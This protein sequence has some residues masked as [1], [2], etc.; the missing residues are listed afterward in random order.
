MRFVCRGF[1]LIELLLVLVI[2]AA[3]GSV[4]LPNITSGQ[5]TA[6]LTSAARD[7]ASALRYLRGQALLL[8][9]ETVFT[10]NLENNEYQVS[11]RDK[12]FQIPEKIQITLDTAQS[13]IIDEG[14]GRIRFYPDGSSTGGRV[15]LKLGSVS[16]QVD[17]NWLTGGIKITDQ[18]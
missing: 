17:I 10:L 2:I 1:T 15:T 18:D 12:K 4:A 13:E 3:A 6:R 9:Q 11:G 7:V 8:H 5:D 14:M 16:K